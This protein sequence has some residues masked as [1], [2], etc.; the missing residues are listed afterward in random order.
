MAPQMIQCGVIH[1]A[2]SN[3]KESRECIAAGLN[4]LSE[5]I[6]EQNPYL[7][8]IYQKAQFYLPWALFFNGQWG[9]ALTALHASIEVADKN[10]DSFPAQILRLDSL[11]RDGLS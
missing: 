8:I 4:A 1:W 11:P 3:Y 9:E 6:G 7:N 5:A 10:G 2:S